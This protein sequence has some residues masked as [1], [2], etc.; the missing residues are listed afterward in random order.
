M[1]AELL[2]LPADVTDLERAEGVADRLDDLLLDIAWL[3]HGSCS[4]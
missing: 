3:F 4:S 1:K 2:D